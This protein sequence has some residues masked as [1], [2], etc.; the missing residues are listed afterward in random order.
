MSFSAWTCKNSRMK[1]TPYAVS[2]LSHQR[3]RHNNLTIFSSK[4][5]LNDTVNSDQYNWMGMITIDGEVTWQKTCCGSL[6]RSV[7]QR[8]EV[9]TWVLNWFSSTTSIIQPT[10]TSHLIFHKKLLHAFFRD[11]GFLLIPLPLSPSH[12]SNDRRHLDFFLIVRSDPT[13]CCWLS[14][15]NQNHHSDSFFNR[16]WFCGYFL[17]EVDHPAWMLLLL[18]ELSLSLNWRREK[19]CVSRRPRLAD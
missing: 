3:Y 14:E 4:W 12:L 7:S 8:V 2:K 17:Q 6:G 1:C 13:V 18:G 15:R 10:K 11:I 9:R 5:L 16:S 19:S